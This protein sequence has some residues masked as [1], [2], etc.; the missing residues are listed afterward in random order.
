MI[1]G[2][3]VAGAIAP[4][5]GPE[6]AWSAAAL[7]AKVAEVGAERPLAAAEVV[8]ALREIFAAHATPVRLMAL[9][10]LAGL[11][12][13]LVAGRQIAVLARANDAAAAALLAT[14]L[15]GQRMTPAELL[16]SVEAPDSAAAEVSG[17]VVT[18]ALGELADRG[19]AIRVVPQ[20]PGQP[21]WL[22]RAAHL[23]RSPWVAPWL[24]GREHYGTHLLDLACARECSQADAVG[25]AGTAYAFTSSLEPAL[26]RRE[27]FASGAAG[28]GHRLFSAS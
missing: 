22:P 27:F 8:P 12:G 23:A 13:G 19:T 4:G 28:H 11:P 20:L 6:G 1:G 14:S 26:A 5:P 10:R 16:V 24:P 17:R 2:E 25:F 9:A 3:P 18:A 7:R 21:G 15:A